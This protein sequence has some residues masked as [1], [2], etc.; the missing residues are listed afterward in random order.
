MPHNCNISHLEH[1]PVAVRCCGARHPSPLD[2][3]NGF[4]QGLS[5]QEVKPAHDPVVMTMH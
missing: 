5:K 2:D 1:L 4:A 3:I